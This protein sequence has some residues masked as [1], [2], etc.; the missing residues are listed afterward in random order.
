MCVPAG[1]RQQT[2]N[3]QADRVFCEPL[4][5]LAA[6]MGL[7]KDQVVELIRSIYG[8]VDAPRAWWTRVMRDLEAAGWRANVCEPCSWS[9]FDGHGR[10]VGICCA[11]VDDF[12]LAGDEKSEDYLVA[13]RHVKDLDEWSEW[14]SRHFLQT[15]VRVTQHADFSFT[16]DQ[17]H[18]A[19]TIDVVQLGRERRLHLDTC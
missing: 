13:E 19:S 11:H 8:L 10:L 12:L 5:E 15:G 18:Y 14:E 9:F 1:R 3:A 4:P 7:T 2:S 16:L 17:S 6:A